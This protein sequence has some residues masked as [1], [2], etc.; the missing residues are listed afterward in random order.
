MAYIFLSSPHD[1]EH[2]QSIPFPV[3]DF[4][5]FTWSPDNSNLL[6][7]SKGVVE[8]EQHCYIFSLKDYSFTEIPP[9]TPPDNESIQ[10]LLGG[11]PAGSQ[12]SRPWSPDSQQ[13]LFNLIYADKKTGRSV[14]SVLRVFDLKT[15]SYSE[16]F[17]IQ[18]SGTWLPASWVPLSK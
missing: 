9:V 12:N 4:Y 18:S 14:K 13:I 6:L 11:V 8:Q 7:C 17:P 3:V 15:Q 10:I 2:P 16:E 5:S 1:M